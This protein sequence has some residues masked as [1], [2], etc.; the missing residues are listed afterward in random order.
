MAWQEEH[1]YKWYWRLEPGVSFTCAIPYDQMARY[2]KTYGSTIALWE[3]PNT[4]PGL[5]RAVDDFRVRK[6]LPAT[7][8]WKADPGWLRLKHHDRTGDKWNLCR[9]WSNFEIADLDFFSAASCTGNC[10]STSTATRF[11]DEPVHSLAV[12][13]LL[14]PSQVHHFAD[15][16]Y[17]H[18]PCPGNAP[19]GQLHNTTALGT[20]DYSPETPGAIGCRCK[21]LDDRQ[22]NNRGTCLS[23]L[24]SPAAA[25]YPS[26]LQ[27][28]REHYPYS[29]N[30][31]CFNCGFS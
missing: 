17:H 13:L 1:K 22:R 16:A 7:A 5:F 10:S 30:V 6:H 15:N 24:Q 11:G 25:H 9:Y 8:M 4:C 23:K 21:C 14:E 18:E 12:H 2:G 28:I 19:G 3:E 27:R 29:I 26:L 20:G 31:P